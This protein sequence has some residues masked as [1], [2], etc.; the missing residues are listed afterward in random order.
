MSPVVENSH[1][2]KLGDSVDLV[3][4]DRHQL[5][6]LGSLLKG[7]ASNINSPK[8]KLNKYQISVQSHKLI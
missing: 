3:G 1:G 4:R 7:H 5:G 2:G 8:T 6:Y